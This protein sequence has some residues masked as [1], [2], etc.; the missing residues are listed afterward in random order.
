MALI[1]LFFLCAVISW[2]GNVY[3]WQCRN[4]LSGEG[5][6]WL[7][8][9][10]MDNFNRSPWD[11]V[12]LSTATVSV[13]SES[14]IITGFNK[15]KYLRQKRAYMLV[16]LILFLI[17]ICVMIFTLL[18]GNVL[19]SAFGTLQNSAMQKGLFPMLAIAFYVIAVV[20]G[21]ATGRFYNVD[22]IFRATVALPAKIAQYFIT[23]F[24]ASQ[25]LSLLL[26]AFCLDYTPGMDYPLPV[27]CLAVGLY[28][29]PLLCHCFIAYEK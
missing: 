21:Y 18:P 9:M 5:V 16:L 22:D 12:V 4:V 29:V 13:I 28:V 24:V 23:M 25:F 1:V 6:R 19:M 17:A 26:F 14:G 7:V 8:A 15:Q 20:Y 3:G 2:I 11:Y 10:I 27:L